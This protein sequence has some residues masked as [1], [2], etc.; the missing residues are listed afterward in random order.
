M[1]SHSLTIL[2]TT[3]TKF[4]SIEVWCTDQNSESLETEDNVNM[5]LILGRHYKNE[6]FNRT[7]ILK[8]R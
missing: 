6:I 2:S 8:I 3:N 1:S 5:M 4:S 7:R